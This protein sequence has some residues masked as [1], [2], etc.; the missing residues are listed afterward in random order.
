MHGEAGFT[1]VELLVVLAIVALITT[2]YVAPLSQ[3]QV[4]R[5]D[6]DR[7]TRVL[8]ADLRELRQHAIND[9]FPALVT[10]ETGSNAY[11]RSTEPSVRHLPRQATLRFT[12]AGLDTEIN[13]IFFFPDGTSSG[14]VIHMSAGAREYQVSVSWPFGRVQT[15][16]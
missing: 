16:D 6:M 5:A 12:P 13:R 3:A 1:L 7:A 14:G 10:F 4:D 15:H 9:G 11:I 8:V 2:L